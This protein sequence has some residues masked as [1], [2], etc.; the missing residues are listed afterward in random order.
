M[1]HGPGHANWR[2][3]FGARPIMVSRGFKHRVRLI[4]TRQREF[5]IVCAVM[6]SHF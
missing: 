4:V 6:H 5:G 1:R 3:D 2:C